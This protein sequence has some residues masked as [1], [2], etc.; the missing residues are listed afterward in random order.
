[1]MMNSSGNSEGEKNANEKLPTSKVWRRTN[2]IGAWKRL[3]R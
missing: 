1:M 3:L 2:G